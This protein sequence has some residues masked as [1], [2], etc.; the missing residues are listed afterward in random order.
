MSQFVVNLSHD[1]LETHLKAGSGTILVDFW[2]PWCGPCLAYAPMI[3]ELAVQYQSRVMVAKLDV[4]ANPAASE[5]FSVRGVPTLIVFKDGVEVARNVGGLN[6]TRL[7][8]LL[9]KNL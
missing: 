2:A 8:L 6:K 9:D 1:D 5:R 4:E 7:S 3:E